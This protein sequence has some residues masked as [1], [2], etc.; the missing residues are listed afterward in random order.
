MIDVDCCCCPLLLPWLLL[1]FGRDRDSFRQ[2]SL[3]DASE[4]SFGDSLKDIFWV[5]FNEGRGKGG[6]EGGNGGDKKANVNT[7]MQMRSGRL[8]GLLGDFRIH[9]AH[10]RR[11]AGMEPSRPHLHIAPFSSHFATCLPSSP[12]SF[13]PPFLGICRWTSFFIAFHL[14]IPIGFFSGFFHDSFMI[15]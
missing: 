6:G 7:N 13:L 8:I 2:D 3:G 10:F 4:D 11:N 5:L 1:K 12:L 15:L 14:R 9:S